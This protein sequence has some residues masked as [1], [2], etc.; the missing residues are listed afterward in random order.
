MR[1]WVYI[2]DGS[3]LVFCP[4][5]PILSGLTGEFT[6]VKGAEQRVLSVFT[7]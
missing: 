7:A 4:R 3:R 5:S 1:N 6:Y 2:L